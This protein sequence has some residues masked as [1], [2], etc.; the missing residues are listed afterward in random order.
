MRWM[1][2]LLFVGC[3]FHITI[4]SKPNGA[5]TAKDTAVR[6]EETHEVDAP[7]VTPESDW[8]YDGKGPRP[9]SMP[10]RRYDREFDGGP[11]FGNGSWAQKD[12]D[13]VWRRYGG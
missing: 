10:P 2:L 5:K 12:E 9:A 8:L 13:G 1:F 3:E 4:D 7:K 6:R 11:D